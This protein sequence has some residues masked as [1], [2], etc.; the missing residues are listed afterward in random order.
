MDGLGGEVFPNGGLH[1][2]RVRFMV[3]HVPDEVV[4]K[5]FRSHDVFSQ[6]PEEF[7]D[8]F[9]GL[10]VGRL[11]TID[12]AGT[13]LGDVF[14]DAGG[15]VGQPDTTR[16]E[17]LQR[18]D[19]SSTEDANH[20]FTGYPYILQREFIRRRSFLAHF[21]LVLADNK[22]FRVTIH[23]KAGYSLLRFGVEV[24][25]P[26]EPT[27]RNP[28][29]GPVQFVIF[30]PFVTVFV[31]SYAGNV[32]E[33]VRV[34]VQVQITYFSIRAIGFI[35]VPV[36]SESCRLVLR[37]L[38]PGLQ[39]I[40]VKGQPGCVKHRPPLFLFLLIQIEIRQVVLVPVHTP[41]LEGGTCFDTTGVRSSGRFR[42]GKCTDPSC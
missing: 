35:I 28:H 14:H 38:V 13:S 1:S 2:N 7:L 11:L 22:T 12:V 33:L 36:K 4:R 27:V 21:F 3:I 10:P 16:V 18:V 15:A 31:L 17:R 37:P 30:V 40:R 9:R 20:V 29:L 24:E 41:T 42:Q 5:G 32:M 19:L 6:T 34:S 25:H 23:H 39:L 26:G 8:L